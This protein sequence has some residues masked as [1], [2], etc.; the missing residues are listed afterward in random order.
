MLRASAAA[1]QGASSPRRVARSSAHRSASWLAVAWRGGRAMINFVSLFPSIL[2]GAPN[3]EAPRKVFRAS[4]ARSPS[5]P[6]FDR[7]R[8]VS[9][10]KSDRHKR[11]ARLFIGRARHA[12]RHAQPEGTV[13]DMGWFEVA[14]L[15]RRLKAFP[16]GNLT[17]PRL[18]PAED[19]R[20]G[21]APIAPGSVHKIVSDGKS[22]RSRR[23]PP[24]AC[25]ARSFIPLSRRD[26]DLGY[27]IDEGKAVFP[28]G[29]LI[30]MAP[31]P[32][33]REAN[34]TRKASTQRRGT[35]NQKGYVCWVPHGVS[36]HPPP[37]PQA[38]PAGNLTGNDGATA[39][40]GRPSNQHLL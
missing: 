25:H 33:A 11:P 18:I 15:P 36:D 30:A 6:G 37:P 27:E 20:D 29:N 31:C 8:T 26:D 23:P 1:G 38:F 35:C 14:R 24:P 10:R 21:A 32:S 17:G 34:P 7:R 39:Q 9:G 3:P 28:A 2:A 13:H 4:M 19:L 5:P 40:L 16:A 22:D 12:P